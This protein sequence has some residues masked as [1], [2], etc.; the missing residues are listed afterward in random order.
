MP[1]DSSPRLCWVE[2]SNPRVTPP[3]YTTTPVMPLTAED[4]Q[5]ATSEGTEVP[6]SAYEE[7]AAAVVRK[8]T[9]NS[10]QIVTKLVIE[11]GTLEPVDPAPT[12]FPSQSATSEGAEIPTSAYEEA[13]AA[14]VLQVV[15]KSVQVVKKLM[16]EEGTLEPVDPAP[17][18][19]Q[20]RGATSEGAV[21][22]I[23]AFEEAGAALVRQVIQNSVQIVTKL[24]MED[25]T[26][27]P[28]DPAPTALPS[29]PPNRWRW[30]KRCRRGNQSAPEQKKQVRAPRA[31]VGCFPFRKLLARL[32]K[33]K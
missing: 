12:P 10:V 17:A 32:F 3:P 30:W 15:E 18:H 5:G 14:V 23:G 33:R 20:S 27:E 11:Q 7:A 13:G 24:M 8:V 21:L 28:V 4:S 16:T 31:E 25:G 1:R 2:E 26:Q 6:I 29:H 22:P 9:E 19:L